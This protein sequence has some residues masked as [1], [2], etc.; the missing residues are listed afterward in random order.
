MSTSRET[1]CIYRQETEN[2]GLV[3][4]AWVLRKQTI[5][6]DFMDVILLLH[7][8]NQSGFFCLLMSFV[9]VINL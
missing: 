3:Y 1:P 9:H 4:L 2:V 7:P 5:N 6:N 8:Y